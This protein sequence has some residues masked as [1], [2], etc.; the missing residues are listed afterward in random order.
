MEETEKRKRYDK[1]FKISA[2]KMVL[3][4]GNSLSSVARDLGIKQ[5]TLMNWKKKYLGDKGKTL[6][7]YQDPKDAEIMRL[8]KELA[9]AMQV[10]SFLKKAAAYFSQN[11]R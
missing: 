2:V 5:N 11:E 7:G 6:S 9:K 8:R 4:G 3:E 1:E 10:N